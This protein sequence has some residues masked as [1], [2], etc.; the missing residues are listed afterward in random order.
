MPRTFRL[1]RAWAL[2]AIAT[3]EALWG[4]PLAARELREWRRRAL[5]IPEPAIREDA[6]RSIA[7]KRDHADGAALFSVLPRRRDPRLLRLLVAYQTIWDF[8]DDVSERPTETGELNGRQLHRALVEA[9][10]PDAGRSDYYRFHPWREDGGYLGS[11]VEACREICAELPS[12]RRTRE[13]L[14]AGVARCSV[15]SLNHEQDPAL[16]ELGLRAWAAR[17][18]PHERGLSW[19]ELTAAASAFLPHVLL[20]VGAEVTP[21]PAVLPAA[22]AAYF[23]WVSLA[24]AMLD[25][26]SDRVEDAATGSHS[27]IAHYD[28]GEPPTGRLCEIVAAARDAVADLPRGGRHT[29]IVSGMVAMYLS[30]EGAHRPESRSATRSIVRASGPMTRL[31]LALLRAWRRLHS[32]TSSN[33]TD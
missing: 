3:R 9:L 4:L 12:Y 27:Y 23:P 7:C 1:E 32:G 25:S 31:L 29:V 21:D 10:S 28:G 24:I 15:Q 19:F 5:V 6:L 2:V 20:A 26:Y 18:F 11:L 33:R 22:L 16:R 17:E 14:L 30:K 8:L 13:L